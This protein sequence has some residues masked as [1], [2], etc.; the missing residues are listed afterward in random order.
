MEMNERI[1]INMIRCRAE[2]YC[3]ELLPERV[4][5]DDWGY[6]ILDGRP[7]EN[8]LYEAARD[9][10]RNCPRLAV[11]LEPVGPTDA[12]RGTPSP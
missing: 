9:A 10:V 7:I 3:A 12:G 11:M 4:H 1:R 6:P 5:L 2:G 8:G